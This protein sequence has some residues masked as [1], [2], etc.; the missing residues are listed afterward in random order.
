MALRYRLACGVFSVAIAI[1]GG[2]ALA[3]Q[4]HAN[5][6][7]AATGWTVSR[8]PD[9]HPDFQGVWA[10]NTVTPLQRPKQWEGKTRLTDAEVADLQKFAA[11]IA[12]NDGDAQFGDSFILAVLNKI[13]KPISYDPGTGNYNQFWIVDRDWHDR[14]T[15]LITDPADGKIPPMT[16]EAQ[17][18]RAAELEHRKAHAFEDP[19]V[20]PLGERCV[21]FGVPRLQAAYNS[22]LQIVQTPNYVMIMNEMAHDAR[23]IPLDGRPHLDPHIRVWNGDPRG[24]WD[25]DTL[26]IDTTNFSPKSDFMGAHEN[27]HLTERI[28]RVSRDVLD[29]QFTVDDPTTWTAPWTAMIP[30]RYKNELIYEYACHEGNDAI[31][32]MLRG[33]R[34]EERE[35]AKSRP[36]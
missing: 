20:F 10:N 24:R 21:N 4:S 33:H 34:F 9:G 19:E 27:L 23:V 18:R 13:A 7:T 36:Q 30:L 25:G 26:V 32:D 6:T 2:A 31:P 5:T 22:Y 14:R 11:Q 3:A 28:T 12:E 1:A 16:P 8:L 17:K 29:Y 35:S 15:A